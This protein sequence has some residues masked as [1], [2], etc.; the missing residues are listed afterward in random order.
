[1][2]FSVQHD[3]QLLASVFLGLVECRVQAE[4]FSPLHFEVDARYI[5]LDI[6]RVVATLELPAA[7]RF[8][9]EQSGEFVGGFPFTHGTFDFGHAAH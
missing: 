2:V 8:D 6:G 4:L 1:M 3:R 5:R 9:S 7:V